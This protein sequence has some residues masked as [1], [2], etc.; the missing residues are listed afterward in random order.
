MGESFVGDR[1]AEVARLRRLILGG[2]R[3]QVNARRGRLLWDSTTKFPRNRGR[4]GLTSQTVSSPFASFA[5]KGFSVL[6]RMAAP[7]LRKTQGWGSLN[8]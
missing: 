4:S 2:R 6:W 5:A 8:C 1:R 3:G 7:P